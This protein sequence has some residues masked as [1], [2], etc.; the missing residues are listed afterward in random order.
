MKIYTILFFSFCSV[1]L[2]SL[3]AQDLIGYF[4][5][6]E[7]WWVRH[8]I[9]VN[10]EE[11][12]LMDT[13]VTVNTNRDFDAIAA[14]P[15]SNFYFF[16]NDGA[17]R[18]L[19]RV[20]RRSGALE[21]LID[22]PNVVGGIAGLAFKPNGDLVM[23]AY[24]GPTIIYIYNIYEQ[25][26]TFSQ[27]TLEGIDNF[28]GIL[29]LGVFKNRM[30]ATT[31]DGIYELFLEA[32]LAEL[33]ADNPTSYHFSGMNILENKCG[34]PIL[35]LLNP[36]GYRVTHY[37]V[38]EDR[39]EFQCEIPSA[40]SSLVGENHAGLTS[41]NVFQG[42]SC[43]DTIDLD[44]VD[45]TATGF[46][47]AGVL[48]CGEQRTPISHSSAAVYGSTP[49]DSIRIILENPQDGPDEY[50]TAPDLNPL[51]ISGSGSEKILAEGPAIFQNYETWLPLVE[52]VNTSVNPTAGERRISVIGYYNFGERTDTAVA[53]IIVFGGGGVQA[54]DDRNLEFCPED[55][56]LDL[57]NFLRNADPGGSWTP[58][59]IV[60]LT[61]NNSGN[62]LYVVS[63][64]CGADTA[65]LE[66]F[67]WPG[68]VVSLEGPDQLCAGEEGILYL[69]G[70]VSL[71]D[72]LIWN[73]GS[74]DTSIVV[75]STGWYGLEL[76]YGE[77]CHWSDSIYVEVNDELLEADSTSL[78]T[79]DT[80]VWRGQTITDGGRYEERSTGST[81]CDTLFSIEVE[82][83]T[84][85]EITED[86]ALCEGESRMR[87]GFEIDSV[88]EY[89]FT[90]PSLAA[91]DT[92]V[93]I[94]VEAREGI[95]LEV[96]GRVCS[97]ENYD[98]R[99]EAYPPGGPYEVLSE[100]EDGC[101]TLW[102]LIVIEEQYAS[103]E[104]LA[105]DRLCAPRAEIELVGIPASELSSS[106]WSTGATGIRT[107]I[108]D[109]GFYS[110]E[111][112]SVSGC[113]YRIEKEIE[114]CSRCNVAIPNVFSPNGDGIN[115]WFEI[116]SS[117][118]LIDFRAQIFD[119][120][121]KQIV[122]SRQPDAIWNGR[123]YQPGVYIYRI[124]YKE[125]T[126]QGR[127]EKIEHGTVTLVR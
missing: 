76:F 75:D 35:E 70:E 54:G 123:D 66:V 69:D 107:T 7:E 78:C 28:S 47:Y 15:D 2:S 126:E 122:E 124:S 74:N 5:D 112:E 20:D 6:K 108:E 18:S 1:F 32:G 114:E 101:D 121:G 77:D 118:T 39:F 95:V 55:R 14:G 41:Y 62:Y 26:F 21:E 83:F 12:G 42:L 40:I 88:G 10:V 19:I 58:D 52:Y 90:L 59:N 98:F 113:I 56:S 53:R 97:G 17:D 127:I 110:W 82:E 8:V 44:G 4:P 46:D 84:P 36:P 80:I 13:I 96:E 34:E 89:R 9:E 25:E 24:Y 48:D 119:R 115:D 31:G 16:G 103:L 65:R 94:R 79:G 49:L 33:L 45:V 71:I 81:G 11:C 27:D 117:C 86:L 22:I 38:G 61:P 85:V 73:T 100:V 106:S 30:F 51:T 120:W 102:Q 92:Q 50:L 111:G 109:P 57:N 23:G 43:R 105:P 91:C 99:G 125:D 72:S 37:F 68:P 64:S 60:E 67:I 93:V 63:D 104:I 87:Y 116:S 3:E 29:S